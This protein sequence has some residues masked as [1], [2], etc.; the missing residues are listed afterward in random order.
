MPLSGT[1]T[2]ENDSSSSSSYSAFLRGRRRG[3][4]SSEHAHRWGARSEVRKKIAA[5][6]PL[7]RGKGR[8]ALGW[9]AASKRRPT[10]SGC[11]TAVA[12]RPL[13]LRQPPLPRW[14]FLKRLRF[15]LLRIHANTLRHHFDHP[16]ISFLKRS[17]PINHPRTDATPASQLSH[18]RL[19]HAGILQCRCNLARATPDDPNRSCSFHVSF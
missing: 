3:R 2:H 1:T 8:Q 19:Q 12:A 17:K 18:G 4:F 5:K 9:V 13:S 16:R 7:G 14:D 15:T 10:P 11:A 6:S